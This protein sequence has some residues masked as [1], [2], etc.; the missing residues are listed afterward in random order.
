MVYTIISLLI[1]S[2]ILAIDARKLKKYKQ[3]RK[4]EVWV[5]F[6]ILGFGFALLIIHS[7]G[8]TIPTPLTWISALLKPLTNIF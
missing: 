5:Y 4:R 6:G 2:V 3:S 8:K 1:V 7:S